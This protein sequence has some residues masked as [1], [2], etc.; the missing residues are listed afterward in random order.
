MT[1]MKKNNVTI[2]IPIRKGS[3][4][5]INKNIKKLPNYNYGLTEI[6]INQLINLNKIC[7]NKFN[8]EIIIGTDCEVVKSY[9]KKFSLIKIFE[10]NK[11]LS[12]DHS[13]Q[14][15]INFL[16]KICNGEFILWTHVT[17]PLFNEH[18]YLNFLESFFKSKKIYD[19][20]F[21]ADILGKFLMNNKQKWVSH[22]YAKKKWPR[23][24]DLQDLFICN[25]AA[26]IS[27][28]KNYLL[29]KDRLGKK[30]IPIISRK[31]S[32]LDIDDQDDFNFLKKI[33]LAK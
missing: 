27:T 30:P 18:D 7:K 11:I 24:Q 6:K 4:R 5:I 16:P 19:S 33:V 2:F 13:L 26:F 31:Y 14:K 8:I 3:K 28:K 25:S 17:S 10:R 1:N 15:L 21:S 9:A 29:Y 12:A 23:T 22:N 32:S 20:G